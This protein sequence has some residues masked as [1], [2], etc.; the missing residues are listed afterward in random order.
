MR[1]A[2]PISYGLVPVDVAAFMHVRPIP[3]VWGG[4]AAGAHLDGARFAGELSWSS[5]LGFGL[6]AGVDVGAIRG[7]WLAL[8]AR[9]T[10]SYFSDISFGSIG[11]GLAYRR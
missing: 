11:V 6:E 5:A 2:D 3:R 1:L 9:V 8:V 10:A 4:F 7:N